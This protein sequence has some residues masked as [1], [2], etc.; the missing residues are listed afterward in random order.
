MSWIES[1]KYY[2]KPFNIWTHGG[3]NL[4]FYAVISKNRVNFLNQ[5][6]FLRRSRA[7]SNPCILVFQAPLLALHNINKELDS[8]Y[9]TLYVRRPETI[10]LNSLVQLFFAADKLHCFKQR[11]ITTHCNCFC[12]C[13][14]Q[15]N[16]N[17]ILFQP[18]INNYVPVLVLWK[19]ARLRSRRRSFGSTFSL[20]IA[21]P[22]C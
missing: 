7:S 9:R 10:S 17:F 12:N 8:T 20:F 5:N 15:F 19:L 4:K 21:E 11:N 6:F 18:I 22:S 3:V 16:Y 2:K 13:F 14:N 1:S